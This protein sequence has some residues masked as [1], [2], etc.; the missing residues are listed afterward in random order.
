MCYELG[1]IL[2]RLLF[3]LPLVLLFLLGPGLIMGAF[4]VLG[5][6]LSLLSLLLGA[7]FSF[8]SFLFVPLLAFGPWIGLGIISGALALASVGFLML[9]GMMIFTRLY[10]RFMWV[11][12][13]ALIRWITQEPRRFHDTEIS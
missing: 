13:A 2:I 7:A 9:L 11:S 6:M 4:I 8:G 10:F 5:Y 3:L 1:M 12:L